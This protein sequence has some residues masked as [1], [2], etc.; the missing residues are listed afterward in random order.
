MERTETQ[1]AK[2]R[3]NLALLIN[4]TLLKQNIATFFKILYFIACLMME[5]LMLKALFFVPSWKNKMITE[6]SQITQMDGSSL[7]HEDWQDRIHNWESLK[8]DIRQFLMD[9]KKVVCL[10]SDAFNANLV[11]RDGTECKLLDFQKPGRPLVV[12]FGSST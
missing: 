8:S 3:L 6:I 9:L 1:L 10:G 4:P 2:P 5:K 7:E 11:R 12:N